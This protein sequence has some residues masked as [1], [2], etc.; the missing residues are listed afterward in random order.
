MKRQAIFRALVKK[1]E[2]KSLVSG[3]KG[4]SILLQVDDPK[5]DLLDNLNRLH[6]ADAMVNVAIVESKD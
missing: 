6:R 2:V 1:I 5:D 4:A 3:D